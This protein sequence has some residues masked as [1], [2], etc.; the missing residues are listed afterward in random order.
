MYHLVN[1]STSLRRS[2]GILRILQRVCRLAFLNTSG[3]SC[4]WTFKT[5][6]QWTHFLVYIMLPIYS[7]LFSVYF[8][9]FVFAFPCTYLIFPHFPPFSFSFFCSRMAS[10]NF[11]SCNVGAIAAVNIRNTPQFSVIYYIGPL[12]ESVEWEVLC[13]YGA[14]WWYIVSLSHVSWYA[15]WHCSRWAGAWVKWWGIG[16]AVTCQRHSVIEIVTKSFLGVA[17]KRFGTTNDLAAF[18]AVW[19]PK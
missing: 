4:D 10:K 14:G 11:P 3:A 7:L 9:V 13:I 16:M 19:K 15:S 1:S 18:L 12:W 6:P 8:C 17:L 2:R 5:F